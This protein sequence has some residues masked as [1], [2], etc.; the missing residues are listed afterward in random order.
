VTPIRR[1]A[2]GSTEGR[3]T[4]TGYAIEAS[5]NDETF[6]INGKVFKAQ[7]YCFNLDKGDRVKFIE[8]SPVAACVSAKLLNLRSGDV[9]A[10]WCGD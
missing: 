3:G 1:S 5:S 6:V 9:C 7:T 8:G 10:V 4:T 2:S